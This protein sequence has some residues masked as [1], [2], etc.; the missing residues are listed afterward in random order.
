M[1]KSNRGVLENVRELLN[2]NEGLK[3]DVE[4][5][6]QESLRI[7]KEGWK[8]EKRVIRDINMIVKTVMMPPGKR[9]RYCFPA[10]RGVE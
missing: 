4:K 10:K 6:T 9:E 8:N 5:F 3:K 2:E 7:M 1:F